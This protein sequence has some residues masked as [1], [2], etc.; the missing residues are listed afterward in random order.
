MNYSETNLENKCSVQY[1]KKWHNLS[2]R[3]LF[4]EFF[5]FLKKEH[6]F[7]YIQWQ[8]PKNGRNFCL[9][10]CIRFFHWRLPFLVSKKIGLS[11]IFSG[12]MFFDLKL[13]LL[14]C[15]LCRV[16]FHFLKMFHR[17]TFLADTIRTS[18]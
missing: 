14:R 9:D 5:V 13:S 7:R 17:E 6:H 10:Y 2:K 1:N 3:V 4:T 12:N 16:P 15:I 11:H 8:R 18:K